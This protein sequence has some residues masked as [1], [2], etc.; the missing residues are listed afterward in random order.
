MKERDR[1]YMGYSTLR[2]ITELIDRNTKTATELNITIKWRVKDGVVIATMAQGDTL[3]FNKAF[4][5]G[6]VHARLAQMHFE[7]SLIL[8]RKLDI[9]QQENYIKK[10][11]E[12]ADLGGQAYDVVD[13]DPEQ[14]FKDMHGGVY[15]LGGR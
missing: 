6:Y 14:R 5:H 3:I 7:F 15:G 12:E 4:T 2:E 9:R 13:E 10:M 11:Q 1:I 8:A